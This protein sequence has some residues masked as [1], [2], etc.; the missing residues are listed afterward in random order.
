VYAPA[1]GAGHF[2]AFGILRF[3]ADRGGHGNFLGAALGFGND[4]RRH[5]NPFIVAKDIA[6]NEL[7]A[8]A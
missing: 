5:R 2:A 8:S 7:E 1:L 3:D 4:R 6:G